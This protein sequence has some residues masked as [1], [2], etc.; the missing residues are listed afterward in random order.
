MLKKKVR[1]LAANNPGV[2]LWNREA[3]EIQE[4]FEAV[5]IA[6]DGLE[7]CPGGSAV[8]SHSFRSPHFKHGRV[9]WVAVHAF[10][11]ATGQTE[12]LAFV[13]LDVR[14]PRPRF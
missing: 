11:I 2:S 7:P 1:E 4:N 5:G 12:S 3:V 9:K 10:V 8:K 13:N 6:L 14:N